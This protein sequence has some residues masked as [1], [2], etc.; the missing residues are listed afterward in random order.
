MEFSAEGY[1]PPSM[2]K[3]YE[4]PKGLNSWPAI[5]AYPGVRGPSLVLPHG[6]HH[7]ALCVRA[8][9]THAPQEPPADHWP[10][11]VSMILDNDG[12][13]KYATGTTEAA[14]TSHTYTVCGSWQLT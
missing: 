6:N 3:R 9:H 7:I 13:L 4:A 12:E 5:F 10:N 2:L 11:V 8:P 14:R 1:M